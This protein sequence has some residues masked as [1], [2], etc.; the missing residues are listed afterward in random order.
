GGRALGAHRARRPRDARGDRPLSAV[1]DARLRARGRQAGKSPQGL[2]PVLTHP[3]CNPPLQ[4]KSAPVVKPESSPASHATIEP[5][6]AGVPSRF[7]GIFAMTFS[8]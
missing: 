1:N 8:R 7:T 2:L 5:I 6:S 3:I 4:E